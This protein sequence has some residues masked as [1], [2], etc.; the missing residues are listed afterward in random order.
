MIAASILV[1]GVLLYSPA[2]IAAET[3]VVV[4][5]IKESTLDN[6]ITNKENRLVV[7]FMAA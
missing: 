3:R 5:P 7:S 4:A 6:M 2:A 1:S